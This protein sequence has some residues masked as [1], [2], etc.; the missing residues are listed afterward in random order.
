MAR[1]GMSLRP[2][3][4]IKHVVDFSG[5]LS[6][7]TNLNTLL[8]QSL[9]APVLANT[10]EVE[11]GSTVNG[12]YLRVEVASNDPVDLGIIPQVYLA[13]WKDP[14]GNLTTPDPSAIGSNDN[15]RYIIHQ[16]MVMLQNAGQGSNPRTLFNGVIVIPKGYRRMAVNDQLAVVIR[17]IQLDIAVCIQC[18]YK[19]FR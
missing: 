16:E 10:A 4:R 9:D 3:H 6:K 11:S 5:T 13:V 18:H 2:V 7:A 1:R 17:S 14:G 8:V 12:I 19:E 15:K